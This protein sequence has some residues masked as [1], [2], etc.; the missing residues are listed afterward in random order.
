MVRCVNDDWAEEEEID[1]LLTASCMSAGSANLFEDWDSLIDP[2]EVLGQIRKYDAQ[3][4]FFISISARL[5]IDAEK[6]AR[7]K[8]FRL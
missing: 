6:C 1:H 7:P 5:K 2:E 8:T 3:I 4:F